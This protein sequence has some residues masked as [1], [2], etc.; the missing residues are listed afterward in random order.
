MASNCYLHDR[1]WGHVKVRRVEL[2][3]PVQ[4]RKAEL[5]GFMPFL[6]HVYM[7]WVMPGMPLGLLGFAWQNLRGLATV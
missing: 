2:G 7:A 4:V 6:A 5:G 1:A 3:G